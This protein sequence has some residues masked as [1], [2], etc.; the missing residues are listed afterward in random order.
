MQITEILNSEPYKFIFL[1][2]SFKIDKFDIY[3]R[4]NDNERNHT[5]LRVVTAWT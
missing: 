3:L 1:S 4:K 2:F 5:V